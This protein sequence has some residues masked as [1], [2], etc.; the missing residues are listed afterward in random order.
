MANIPLHEFVAVH[1]DAIIARCG[2]TAAMRSTSPAADAGI[3]HGVPLFVD[4]LIHALRFRADSNAEIGRSAGMH[5]HDLLVQGCTIAQ[6]V[7]W[8]HNLVHAHAAARNRGFESLPMQLNFD[9]LRLLWEN[10]FDGKFIYP[11]TSL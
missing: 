3:A 2:V 5:G 10:F 6:V 1:R 11:R 9:I 8:N 4:Q 7:K